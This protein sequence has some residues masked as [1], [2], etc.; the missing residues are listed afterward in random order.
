[1]RLPEYEL[2]E[3]AVADNISRL[4]V[5]RGWNYTQLSERL[6]ELGWPLSP[7]LVKRVESGNRRAGVG[8]LTAFAAALEVSPATLL[9]PGQAEAD[10]P[11]ALSGVPAAAASSVW[12]WVTGRSAPP[13]QRR[14]RLE[15]LPPWERDA[16]L[17]RVEAERAD[18]QRAADSADSADSSRFPRESAPA[19]PGAE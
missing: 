17:E 2:T 4:R 16:V 10:T 18:T 13:G 3:R 1:M 11:V 14:M 5:E 7:V 19:C 15:A 9:L 6:D 8:D 12:A